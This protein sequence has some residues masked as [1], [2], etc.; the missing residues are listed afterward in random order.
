MMT[1]A[2]KGHEEVVE[3]LLKARVDPNLR[4][5]Y[6]NT[7]LH[8]ACLSNTRKTVEYLLAVPNI[9]I[10]ILNFEN[11]PAFEM[12]RN[13]EILQLFNNYFILKK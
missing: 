9:D 1:A 4:D 2:Q 3:K 13:K 11:K 10:T 6:K 8:Y 7:A 12:T 5:I